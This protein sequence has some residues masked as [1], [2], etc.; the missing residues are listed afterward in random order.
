M[1]ETQRED[2]NIIN[3]ASILIWVNITEGFKCY[4]EIRCDSEVASDSLMG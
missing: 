4:T 2:M 3:S 1:L